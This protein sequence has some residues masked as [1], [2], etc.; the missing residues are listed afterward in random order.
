MQSDQTEGRLAVPLA[1]EDTSKKWC[2]SC[3]SPVV[4]YHALA[5][6]GA[7]DVGEL[8]FKGR[9]DG[10]AVQP[11]L[12]SRRRHQRGIGSLHCAVHDKGCTGQRL[13]RRTDRTIGIIVVRPGHTA[14]QR[15]NSVR[16]RKGFVGA[17]TDFAARIRD[18]FGVVAQR[19]RVGA[20]GRLLGI[21]R[22]IERRELCG[23]VGRDADPADPWRNEAIAT[24]K[25]AREC[26]GIEFSA[27]IG[28]FRRWRRCDRW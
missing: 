15:E 7:G 20:D 3:R 16:H 17:D 4:A 1:L 2:G 11:L 28:P 9:G 10:P 12:F 19:E 14:T 18:V 8:A 6:V 26:I 27:Q 5:G 13:E 25:T 22:Q 24:F 23:G 21:S